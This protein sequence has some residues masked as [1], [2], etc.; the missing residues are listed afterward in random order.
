MK[1]LTKLIFI[2]AAFFLINSDGQATAPY[3]KLQFNKKNIDRI[4]QVTDS[5]YE[6]AV[7]HFEVYLKTYSDDLESRYKIKAGVNVQIQDLAEAVDYM[8][9]YICAGMPF[10]KFLKSYPSF[11]KPRVDS[12]NSW[13]RTKRVGS[14]YQHRLTNHPN[15]REIKKNIAYGP[16]ERNVLDLYLADADKPTPLVV[17]IHGGGF[18]K[19]NKE[20]LS[21]MMLELCLQQGLSVA[22][23][24]YRLSDT[25]PFPMQHMDAARAIQFLRYNAKNWNLDPRRVAATGR[26]AGAGI[27]LWLGFHDD[28]A[29]LD[30]DDPVLRQSTRLSCMAVLGAQ[31]TYDPRWIEEHIGGRAHLH[32]A[33]P[34]FFG[35][36]ITEWETPQAYEIFK[37]SAAITYLTA[38]DPSVW[39]I[40]KEPDRDLPPNAGAGEGIHH[41]RFGRKLK[42]QMDEL[43]I[44]C[45]IK[46]VDDY[47]NQESEGKRGE[48]EWP[49]KDFM[50]DMI[51]FFLQHLSVL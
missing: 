36:P 35:I 14:K 10:G 6:A 9:P 1:K 15:L 49:E 22:T 18:R 37:R 7:K 16:H 32:P 21:P 41:P 33:L 29:D 13:N 19:G 23:I 20:S 30:A 50:P 45:I 27:S 11:L 25:G 46:H 47:H 17:Y 26:S 39:A 24:N 28:L 38:D 5:K 48:G 51:D 44:D 43:G 31:A 3:Y 34:L 8:N 40:Y 2:V 12:W 4:A 42:K